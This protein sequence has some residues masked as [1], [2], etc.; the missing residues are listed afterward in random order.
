MMR[1]EAGRRRLRGAR[2]IEAALADGEEPRLLLCP[3]GTLGES[4]AR[5]VR[6][7]E[8]A[9]ADVQ[10]VSPAVLRRLGAGQAERQA[11]ESAEL[12]ALVGPDPGAALESWLARPGAAW[13]LT[14]TA[15][16]GNAGFV[17]R[18]AE[19]S[20]AAGVVIDA[21][22]DRGER[23]ECLRAAMRA[24]RFFP[25]CFAGAA[26]VVAV[27]RRAGRRIVAVEDSGDRAP[28]E[29][30]LCGAVLF[31]VG[32]EHDGVP[33]PLLEEADA[34]LRI[35]MAGFAASYNL[36]AAM[37]VVMGERLRQ[38]AQGTPRRAGR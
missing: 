20:G 27:A 14:G 31:I 16:P 15:Y 25:V 5:L 8:E 35:P 4:A 1:E 38:L 37:A 6:V 23:R 3:E 7:C 19:V 9:G 29:T 13:L 30:D 24:D 17:I 28:W 11:G 21:D 10:R 26:E 34:V 33:Q 36:Q 12:L 18:S 22:F 2:A 32:G